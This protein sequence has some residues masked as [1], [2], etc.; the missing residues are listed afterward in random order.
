[1]TDLHLVVGG[2][3]TRDPLLATLLL[4]HAAGLQWG[5][6]PVPSSIVPSW[7][8][9]ERPGAPTG[10]ELLTVEAHVSRHAPRPHRCLDDVL[11]TVHAVLTGGPVRAERLDDGGVPD[12]GSGTVSRSA[13]WALAPVAVGVLGHP[14][15][16][17]RPSGAASSSR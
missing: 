16:G 5:R 10:G 17:Y 7:A 1:M 4:N 14:A 13:T 9:D 12:I 2:L 3:L 6:L 15:A 8:A 11:D